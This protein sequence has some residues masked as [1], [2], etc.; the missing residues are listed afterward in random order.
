MTIEHSITIEVQ[1]E[2][3]RMDTAR[4]AQTA[5]GLADF[6]NNMLPHGL[7]VTGLNV[8]RYVVT[9]TQSAPTVVTVEAATPVPFDGP[10]EDGIDEDE[11]DGNP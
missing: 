11:E 7:K 3:G 2:D 5:S 6:L 4:L 9:T 10:L 8:S 1:D